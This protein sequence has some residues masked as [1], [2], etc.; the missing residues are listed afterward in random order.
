MKKVIVLGCA[1]AG[2]STFSEK[3]H[4]VT[5][6]PLT[7]LDNV[8]WKADRTHITRDEFDVQLA[9]LLRQEAW[10]LDGDYSRTYEPRFAACDTVFFLD[11]DKNTCMA[12]I[13][14]RLGKPR[15]DI[16]WSESTL[17]PML[18]AQVEQ[19]RT[20]ER[21]QVLAWMKRYAEK[22]IVVFRSRAEAD[23]YISRLMKEQG[24]R[25]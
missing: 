15:P 8:W 6:L 12:G 19:Y 22:E 1:G 13:R 17:D 14:A 18:V 5:G 20:E 21:P 4:A 7:H 9:K 24:G 10:I 11:F 25:L 16:P 2:K 23:A 3:L